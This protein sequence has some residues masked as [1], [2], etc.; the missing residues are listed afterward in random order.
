[1]VHGRSGFRNCVFAGFLGGLNPGDAGNAQHVAF[2]GAAFGNHA[3]SGF[4]H[5]DA[6]ARDGDALRDSL[7]TDVN[8]VR[9][10][11]GVEM[12]ELFHRQ[13]RLREPAVRN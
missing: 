9:L 2:F 10:A 13:L 5:D 6:A 7:G 8:H 11:A 3:E 1:M 4:L 12:R